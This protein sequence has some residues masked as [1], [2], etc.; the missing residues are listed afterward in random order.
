MIPS[1]MLVEDMQ[2]KNID[3]KAVL[4]ILDDINSG[5]RGHDPIPAAAGVPPLDGKT[6]IPLGSAYRINKKIA[7]ES[8]K[9]LSVNIPKGAIEDGKDLVFGN[10]I[11]KEL[12]EELYSITAWG[13]LNGGLATSYA[14]KKKNEAMIPG[15]FEVI[16]PGFER[17]APL[18]DGRPKGLAPAYI[19]PDG[20]QGESFILLKMRAALVKAES[21][22]ERFGSG[23][24]PVLPMFQM[25]SDGT[26]LALARAYEEYRQHPG[27]QLLY[28][29]PAA[30]PAQPCLQNSPFWLP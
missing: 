12:G 22:I 30:T 13:I 10:D 18:C 14:D 24:R 6:I 17:M 25:S 26:D 4:A 2:K 11:L 1:P 20:S 9:A 8:L 23:P 19:N 5:R 21:H 27:Y 15:L 3:V 7:E 29:K 16:K 28:K